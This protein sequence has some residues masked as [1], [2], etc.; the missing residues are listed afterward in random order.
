MHFGGE[1]ISYE[2]LF[3]ELHFLN[4]GLPSMEVMESFLKFAL[5]SLSLIFGMVGMYVL[6]P[7]ARTVM[8]GLIFCDPGA[9]PDVVD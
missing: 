7:D 6:R 4:V 2:L 5:M 1:C 3:C 9:K 8:F